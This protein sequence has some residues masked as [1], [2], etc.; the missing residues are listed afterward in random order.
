MSNI[1][2][3]DLPAGIGISRSVSKRLKAYCIVATLN[4][5]YGHE[6]GL[7]ATLDDVPEYGH[8]MFPIDTPIPICF[9]M[10]PTPSI[11]ICEMLLDDLSNQREYSPAEED[12]LP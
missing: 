3:G 9:L 4:G 7:A 1:S 5:K 12:R 2:S 6:V 11:D 8:G 10:S